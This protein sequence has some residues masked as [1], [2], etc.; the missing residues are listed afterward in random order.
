MVP[1]HSPVPT[2]PHQQM[3]L[4]RVS[5]LPP[6]VRANGSCGADILALDCAPE[7]L[8]S[9]WSVTVSI[10]GYHHLYLHPHY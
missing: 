4:C 10:N 2:L 3:P 8:T 7:I 1:A 5:G 9:I 6:E